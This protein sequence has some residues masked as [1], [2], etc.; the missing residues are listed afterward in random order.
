[1]ALFPEKEPSVPEAVT[2]IPEGPEIPKY[3]E[4]AGVSVRPSQPNFQVKGDNGQTL[5]QTPST[6]S[7]S[8]QVPSDDATLTAWATKGSTS[9]AITWLA[10][11]WLRLIK[12][13]LHF[14]WRI[15][16]RVENSEVK[17]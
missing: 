4:K 11:F 6:Q 2:Q 13:A 1:M 12:K 9:D 5:V 10:A 15:L 14:G 3:I 8:I 7:I 16:G 17:T